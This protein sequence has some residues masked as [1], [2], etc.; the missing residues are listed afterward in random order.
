MK[1]R[2]VDLFAG[3]GGFSLGLTLS[4]SQFEPIFANDNNSSSRKIYSLNFPEVEFNNDSI[5]DLTTLPKCDLITAG[6]P[7]QPFSVCGKR[8]GF[9]DNRANVVWKMFELI[10]KAK[11]RFVLL[12]NVKNIL[13]HNEGKTIEIIKSKIKELGYSIKYKVLNTKDFGIPQNRERVYFV[14]FANKED[15]K[16][17]KF[18]STII[19][20]FKKVLSDKVPDKYYYSSRY[21]VWTKVKESVTKMNYFYQYRRT[22]VRKNEKGLCPTLTAN[23]GKGGHNVPLVLDKKGI[24]KLTPRECFNLQGFPKSY[25]VT[26]SDNELYS[27]A[28]NAI[29]VIVV[30]NIGKQ[31]IKLINES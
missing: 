12:E 6:F 14:C 28:G 13:S 27:L 22:Y 18:P 19:N 21:K 25:V 2:V 9:E 30:K 10:G 3:T 5:F 26:G 11:P 16:A 24:R 23:M 4:S 29:S 20:K 8:K 7:C 17:F 1:V 31:I 15:Y